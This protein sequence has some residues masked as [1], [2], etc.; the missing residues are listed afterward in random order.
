MTTSPPFRCLS[1]IQLD[2]PEKK[3]I[4]FCQKWQIT[5]LA[6]FGSVLRTDFNP[7]TSDIDI[8][9]D[10]SDTARHTLLD[11]TE[12]QDQLT[13][14]FQRKVDLVSRKGLET[15]RNLERKQQIL[16][17]AQT[18]YDTRQ[19]APQRYYEQYRHSSI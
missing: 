6:L 3:L 18:I 8:L 2:L 12:M 10:F 15:S 1:T 4:T 7:T 19:T 17:F 13:Q 11:F 5:R 16:T 9:V 14:I